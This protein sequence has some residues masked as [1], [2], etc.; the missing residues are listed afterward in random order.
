MSAQ[1]MIEKLRQIALEHA[2]NYITACSKVYDNNADGLAAGLA[3]LDADLSDGEYDK[4]SPEDKRRYAQTRVN[5]LE[6]KAK[7]W[8]Q[9]L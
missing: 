3:L 2:N 9:R 8:R 5:Y 4:L 7:T 1:R 6:M